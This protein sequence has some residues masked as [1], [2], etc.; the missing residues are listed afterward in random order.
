MGDKYKAAVETQLDFTY[1]LF[2]KLG[3]NLV[4]SNGAYNLQNARVD[5]GG[6]RKL[7]GTTLLNVSALSA[8]PVITA[9]RYYVGAYYGTIFVCGTNIYGWDGSAAHVLKSGVTA[10]KPWSFVTYSG[11]IYGTNGTDSPIKITPGGSTPYGT[12]TVATMTGPPVNCKQFI[13]AKERIWAGIN[14]TYPDR[15]W[16]CDLDAN[17]KGLAETWSTSSY[18]PFPHE[19]CGEAVTGLGAWHDNPIVFTNSTLSMIYGNSIYEF[20]TPIMDYVG[21]VSYLSIANLGSDLIFQGK[22]GAY[23]FIGQ[24]AHLISDDIQPQMDDINTSCWGNIVGMADERR[25]YLSYTS[26][27]VGGTVNNRLLIFDTTIGHVQDGVLNGGWTGP[28]TI[29]ASSFCYY[30]GGSDLGQV[31]YGDSAN[32]GYIYQFMVETAKDFAGSAIDMIVDTGNKDFRSVMGITAKKWLS[33]IIPVI[34]PEG[35]YNLMLSYLLDN[36]GSWTPLATISLAIS[37]P[38]LGDRDDSTGIRSIIVYPAK[39][40]ANVTCFFVRIRFEQNGTGCVCAVRSLD[41]RANVAVPE[42]K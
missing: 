31:Y 16:Y 33:E 10:G 41:L 5:K 1:G 9:Y 3:P 37:G 12:F 11:V 21:C 26:T 36:A 2:T 20:D 6:F 19:S 22:K 38:I 40:G 8:A 17:G 42:G 25:Y 23:A 34:E 4:P 15:V 35:N 27:L 32:T 30:H 7:Q 13:V 39:F 18:L 28:H 29:G 24:K 14:A